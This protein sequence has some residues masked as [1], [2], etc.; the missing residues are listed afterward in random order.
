[1][2]ELTYVRLS[3]ASAAAL[4]ELPMFVRTTESICG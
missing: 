3:L 2:I 1:V 4:N